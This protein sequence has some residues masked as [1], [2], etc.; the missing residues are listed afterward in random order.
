MV[1]DVAQIRPLLT[2][3]SFSK[4]IFFFKEGCWGEQKAGVQDKDILESSSNPLQPWAILSI[5]FLPSH[6]FGAL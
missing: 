5:L 3:S 2:Q 1:M 4:H 6:T